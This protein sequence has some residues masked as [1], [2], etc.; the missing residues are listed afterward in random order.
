MRELRNIEIFAEVANCQSFSKAAKN[1]MITPSAVS[2]SVQK[3]ETSLGTRL[4]TRTTRQLHLTAEGRA[5]LQGTQE[6]LSRI[7]EAIDLFSNREGPPSGPLRVCAMSTIGRSFIMPVLPQ[8]M[9][10]YPDISLDLCL[11][12]RLPHLIK[13]QFDIGLCCGEPDDSSYIGR[14]LCSPSMVL[15]ASPSYLATNRAPSKPDDLHGHK[16]INVQWKEG[17]TPL[18]VFRQHGDDASGEVHEP[19][20]IQPKSNLNIIESHD[21]AIDAAAAGLGVALVLRKAAAPYITSGALQPLLPGYDV[22]TAE[23]SSFHLLYPSKKYLAKR[24]RVFI[25]FLVEVSERDAWSEGVVS[26]AAPAGRLALA[27]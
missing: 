8:F 21:S 24:V 5:F 4:L 6:G 2:M 9:S 11:R 23:G 18:W 7:Y 16:I 17:A 12:D 1:L 25:D 20:Q 19:V 26:A 27:G 13:D 10:R 3:L 14:R 15:V 22:S